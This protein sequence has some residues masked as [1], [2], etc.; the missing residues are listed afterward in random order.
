MSEPESASTAYPGVGEDVV[1]PGDPPPRDYLAGIGKLVSGAALAHVVTFAAA[2]VITR[3]YGP[4]AYGVAA[5]FSALYLVFAAVAALRYDYAVILPE[6]DEDARTAFRLCFWLILLSS[7]VLALGLGAAWLASSWVRAQP[8]APLL[9]LVP[10]VTLLNALVLLLHAWANRQRA[11]GLLAR[12][13]VIN[14]FVPPLIAIGA[15]FLM[16][17]NPIGL[18]IGW[19][20]AQVTAVMLIV[21]LLRR[22]ATPAP[23]PLP[24]S[25]RAMRRIALRY[26]QFPKYNVWKT[27]MEQGTTL[28]PVLVFASVF[29][30]A[31]AAWFALANNMLRVPT[32][33][34]G[35]AV[36]HVFYER[37]ARMRNRPH[38]LRHLVTRTLLGL[39]GAGAALLVGALL[40]APTLFAFVFGQDWA[41]AGRYTQLLAPLAAMAILTIP[42]GLIPAVLGRQREQLMLSGAIHGARVGGIAAGSLLGSPLAAILLYSLGDVVVSGF[43][44]WWLWRQVDDHTQLGSN[45]VASPAVVGNG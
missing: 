8:V 31:V 33:M 21:V 1:D 5:G 3:L 29:S 35:H 22:A 41:P 13:R 45:A 26:R 20:T 42:M 30:P 4:D 25:L 7:V 18:V 36:S 37:A 11:F 2:P 17:A 10:V 43:Y 24:A 6:R 19:T 27:L 16:G 40:F 32:E 39:A 12:M 15:F 34:V 14:A 38:E 28:L 9:Y 44:L 23:W